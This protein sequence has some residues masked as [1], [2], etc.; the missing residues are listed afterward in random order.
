MNGTSQKVR[1]REHA[2]LPLRLQT[3]RSNLS[4]EDTH[5]HAIESVPPQPER[6]A[7]G[8]N[9]QR[10]HDNEGYMAPRKTGKHRSKASKHS[11]GAYFEEAEF[12]FTGCFKN[13]A[14]QY[15]KFIDNSHSNI[16]IGCM[17]KKDREC[18]SFAEIAKHIG[19]LRKECGGG[20]RDTECVR[21]QKLKQLA[22]DVEEECFK[23]KYYIDYEP[24]K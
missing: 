22:E 16:A 21:G 6:Y 3:A 23:R 4:L 19:K 10:K 24:T 7:I 12:K 2:R 11:T 20:K 15:Q 13:E 18:M 5:T 9:Q 17:M 8:P 14:E 1:V